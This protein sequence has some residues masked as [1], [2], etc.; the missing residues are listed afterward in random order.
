MGRVMTENPGYCEWL[1]RDLVYE[2]RPLLRSALVRHGF[3]GPETLVPALPGPTLH[4]VSAMAQSDNKK[5]RKRQ[6]QNVVQCKNCALCGGDD[7]NSKGCRLAEVSGD[8]AKKMSTARVLKAAGQHARKVAHKKY[9]PP[10]QRS[11][12]YRTR[13]QSRARAPVARSLISL[14]RAPPLVLA[15]W[16]IEAGLFQNLEGCG[17]TLRPG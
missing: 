1:V 13:P 9:T 11:E 4:V 12:L 8:V 2:K 3:L 7:H 6:R 14:Q 17:S 15:Q 16:M 5:S 10:A